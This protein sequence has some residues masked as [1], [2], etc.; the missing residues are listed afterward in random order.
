METN[1]VIVG[2][3]VSTRKG[4]GKRLLAELLYAS[5]QKGIHHLYLWTDMSCNYNYY[6]RNNFEEVAHFMTNGFSQRENPDKMS[7][8]ISI[9]VS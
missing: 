3:F 5:E 6:Y 8:S 2:L 1:D 7:T 4:C 9:M